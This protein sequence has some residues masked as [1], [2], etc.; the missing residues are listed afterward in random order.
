MIKRFI[1]SACMPLILVSLISANIYKRYDVRSGMSGNCVRSILQDSIGYMWFATQDGLN[2][3]NGIEFTNYGHSSENGDN[4]YM[5][6]VTIC[7]HYDNNHIWIASTEKLYLFDSRNE[8]FSAFDKQT[9]DGATVNSAFGMAYDNYGQLWIGTANGLF[10][11]NEKKGT[12]KRYL[13]S[14]SDPYSLPDNHVWV[15][16]NDS[17][18]TIW[19]GTRNGLAK[20]NQHTNNFTTFITKGTSFGHPACNEIISLTESSQGVLWAGTWYGGLARF[21]KETGRFRYYFGEGDTLTIPRIRTLFQRTANSFYLG[22]DDGLYT[23]NP[24]TGECVLT[25]EEHAKESIYA[26]YQDREGGIW[27]G[28]YFSG[29]SYLSPKYKDIEWYYSNGTEHSLSGNVISQFCEDPQG[30]IWIATEDGGLNVFNPR[31][32]TFTNH[33]SKKSNFKIGYHNIH[34]LLYNKGELWIGSFSR[35]LYILN[36]QTKKIKNYRHNQ[37][38]PYSIPND[39]IYSIYKAKNG[40]IYIGTLSGF[41]QYDPKR[42]SFQTLKSLSHIFIYDIIEDQYGNLW[43]A[44]KRDGIWRYNPQTGK[45]HNYRHN[46]QKKN[47]PCSNW[48]IRVYIDHKQNLWFCTEGGGICRY[49]YKQDCF[50]NFSTRDNLPNNIIYGILDDQSGNYWLSSNRG[51]IRYEPQSKRAQLY[52]VEDGLQSNQF[53]F[54]SSLQASDGKFYFGGVNGFNAFYPFKLSVNKVRPTA[55]ISAVYMHSPDD[56]ISRSKRVPA[57]SGKITIPYQVVSFDIMF[58]SLSYVAPGKNLYAYKLDGIHKDWIYTN[59]HNVSFLNLSPGKYTFRVKSS[60]NDEYWSNNDCCLHIEVLPPPWKTIYAKIFYLLVACGFTYYLVRLYLHKQQIVKQRKMKEIEQI[61]NQELFQA[62]ITFFTQVAHEIKTPLSLINAPLEAIMEM[63]EWNNEVESNLSVIQKNSNRLI[64]LVK[65][66]LDFRKVDKE[67]YALSFRQTDINQMIENIIE[68]FRTI[69]LAGISFSVSLPEKHLEYNVDEEAMTKIISNLLTNAMKFAR[70]QI[71][72]MLDEHLSAE[73]HILSI[74][75]RD[76]GPGI[77]KDECSKVFEPFYQVGNV[78]NSGSGVGIGL[79]LVRL[80]VEK[81]NGKV[82]INTDYMAGC[83]ICV[84]IPHLEKSISM[85]HTIFPVFNEKLTSDEEAESSSYSLLV[86]E[87][88]TDMLEFLSKNLGSSY[89]IHTASNGQEALGCLEKTTID[90]I[91]SDI[92]M[93]YMDG[94]ELLKIIRADNMLCHIPFILLSA[95]DSVDSKIAGLDYGADAYIEKPFSLHHMK[96]TINNLLEN[97]RML[98]NHF[99]TV[100]DMSYDQMLMN[101]TDVKWLNTINEIITTNFTNEDFTIDKLAGEMAISRSNLQRKL[102]GLTGMPPNDYIRLIRLKTA[103]ELLQKG[104]YRINEVCYIVGF[105][106]PSYFA[107]CFQ[108]QFGILP[109]DYIRKGEQAI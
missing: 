77:P 17:Y 60:N 98:F 37:T 93:P 101:K 57:L 105:N 109:K 51:L 5:N 52:T 96:A 66:L 16:Y 82:Y 80:L 63:H 91:I 55:S 76:D 11:Y 104:E 89:V 72:I 58:E 7:Q 19:I 107:R 62:K 99:T 47:S 67:G 59:K 73:A 85:E 71:M 4:N 69:S 75:V 29:V 23:F 68:R 70:T 97:R 90:L 44:S 1:L 10:V 92:V 27:I 2:R 94:F 40:N 41:C 24:T 49:H 30:N 106:N 43:M 79:S 48:V 31:S 103:G 95:L 86:V 21:N 18:G 61:K 9:N 83:E 15:I 64:E 36:T 54:R 32:R 46:P 22:S 65:Q 84:E 81:H 3:F 26:C 102:K 13:H 39:H 28:T 87:D 53:N 108:K 14:L 12:L 50:E 8:R 33:L 6:I 100:P 45:L 34:A 42:D 35:G 56:K 74:R 38:N 25:D 88:T 78:S 20:Y